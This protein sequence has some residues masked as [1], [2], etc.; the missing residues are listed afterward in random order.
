MNS[1]HGK[2]EL[3]K[4]SIMHLTLPP[5]P[6]FCFLMILATHSS[7]DGKLR[8]CF[9][10]DGP[11]SRK[12]FPER[13]STSSLRRL[14]EAGRTLSWFPVPVNVRRPPRWPRPGGK[15]TSSLL[16]T[17]RDTKHFNWQ[18]YGFKNFNL[19]SLR[20]NIHSVLLNFPQQNP[21]GISV[22]R[23]SASLISAK[24]WIDSKSSDKLC[25]L[26]WLRSRALRLRSWSIR[27]STLFKLH[28]VACRISSELG[29]EVVTG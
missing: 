20:S 23:L 5:P 4:L 8:R 15:Q 1:W 29:K 13:S 19:F 22:R 7:K 14:K 18:K 17:F 16:S 11:S 10:V 25:S 24:L 12:G 6:Y 2:R 21:A 28:W 26:L 3:S 9:T 27:E